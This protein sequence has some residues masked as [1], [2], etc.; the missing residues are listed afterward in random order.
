MRPIQYRSL[1]SA[2]RRAVAAVRSYVRNSLRLMGEGAEVRGWI[3]RPGD[4]RVEIANA[5]GFVWAFPVRPELYAGLRLYF[6]QWED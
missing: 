6:R 5:R 4:P 1:S 2:Q 3:D